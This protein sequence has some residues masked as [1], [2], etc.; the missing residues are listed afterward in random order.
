MLSIST[1]ALGLCS[2]ILRVATS[3]LMPGKAQ[4]ITI[5]LGFKLPC[6]A[7]GL[8]AVAGFAFDDDVFLVFENAPKTAAHQRVIVNQK[9]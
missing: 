9:D 1:A 6:H 4:S 8:F 3:P 5:T 7:H 2:R